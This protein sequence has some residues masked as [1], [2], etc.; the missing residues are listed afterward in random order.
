VG[1]RALGALTFHPA[2]TL[3]I[4][5]A[6]LESLEIAALVRD[7]RNIV[8][9]KPEV[10]IPE[11]YRIGASAGGLRP[12]A[13][14]L[15]DARSRQIRSANAT[16]LPDD[17]RCILKFDGVGDGATAH[18]LGR[19]QAYNRVEAAYTAM[20]QAAGIETTTITLLELD[21][22]AHLLVHRFDVTGEQRLHQHTFGGLVHVDYNDPGASSY[23]EYLRS[24]LRL[25]MAYASVE[26]GYRRMVFNVLAVNQD[27][28]V[29]NLSFQ[30][31][32]D[33]TWRLAPAYDLTFA[34]GHGWTARHQ[35]RVADKTEGL[36][37]RDL[38]AVGDSF[39]INDP[40][41]VIVDTQ[42]ALARWVEFAAATRVPADTVRAIEAELERRRSAL[43]S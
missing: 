29:K 18:D 6:E 32:P 5:P 11:I 13:L 4:R 16:A 38:L 34:L 37:E 26:Q 19:P 1:E 33:G 21:G 31:G 14:V 15:F 7:A 24:V 35:M 3:P 22:Y 28:H 36:R 9:G 41:G 40:R 8:Q 10:S 27:D 20:A 43:A 23:E 39:D 17:T 42:A 12:K 2:E 30:M 25:G